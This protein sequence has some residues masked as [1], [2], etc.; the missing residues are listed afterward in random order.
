[1]EKR[2]LVPPRLSPEAERML[3]DYPPFLRQILYNRGYGD[4]EAAR[5]FLEA[6][7][8]PDTDPFLLT[9]VTQAVDRIRF[10]IQ[11]QEPIAVYGDYDVDGVTATALL[12]QILQRLG[13]DVR[14]YIPNRFDEGYGLNNEALSNLKADGARLVITVDCGIRSPNEA[15][16]ARDIGLDLVISDH[17]H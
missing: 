9:G 7:T 2:W 6:R 4:P 1:M 14:G 8:P 10:A 3:L 15:H 17:H 12:V 5:S 13:A 16:H 11:Q